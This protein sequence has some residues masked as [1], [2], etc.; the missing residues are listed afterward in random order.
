MKKPRRRQH[1]HQ[2]QTS[3]ICQFAINNRSSLSDQLTTT[4][5]M[6]EK[7]CNDEIDKIDEK[8]VATQKGW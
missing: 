6:I 1:Q 7:L 3:E 2:F 5:E 8:D 4:M